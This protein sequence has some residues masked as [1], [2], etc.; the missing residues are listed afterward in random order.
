MNYPL[1]I[2]RTNP[3]AVLLVCTLLSGCGSLFSASSPIHYYT[4]TSSAIIDPALPP[5][6]NRIVAVQTVRLP[7]YLNQNGIVTRTEENAIDVAKDSQWAGALDANATQ[8]IVADLA[9]LLSSTRVVAY[10]VSAALPVDRVVQV[11]ISRFEQ[12]PDGKVVLVAQWTL[13]G[14]GGRTYLTTDSGSYTT[15]PEGSGYGAIAAAMGRLLGSLS[16]DIAEALVATQ[17]ASTRS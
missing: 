12:G 6:G 10:P 9:K 11:D 4:L 1:G 2:R 7:E 5:L 13:F 16:H 8:V 14:D 15:A 17:A 3:I